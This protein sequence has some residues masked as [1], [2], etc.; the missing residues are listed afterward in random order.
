MSV[1]NLIAASDLDVLRES[2]SGRSIVL[3]TG[4]FDILHVG[5]VYFLKEARAQGDVL[6]VGINSDRAVKLIKGPKRPFVGQNDRATILAA[7][8]DV[9]YVFIFDDTVADN[10][11][12]R[13]K[14]DVFVIGE[15]SM[16]AYPSESTAAEAIGARVYPISRSPAPS[17]TSIVTNIK[18]ILNA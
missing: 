3:A 17:T 12:A 7:F 16:K 5:H 14:P 15:E 4:C 13:L 8:R 18:Q 6:V 9:D 2:L 1:E 11:I 10:S